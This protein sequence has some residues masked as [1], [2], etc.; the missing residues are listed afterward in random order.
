V[1]A[2]KAAT[3]TIPIAFLI[4]DDPV[5]LGLVAS[6]VDAAAR[7]MGLQI[8]VINANT[9]LAQRCCATKPCFFGFGF[10]ARA[11]NQIT[12]LKILIFNH[13]VAGS[14][15]ARLTKIIQKN[16]E[17]EESDPAPCAAIVIRLHT[18]ST[19]FAGQMTLVCPA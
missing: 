18:I 8:Q 1:L 4:G 12:N 5:K 16:Q 11:G 10:P 14:T 2:A 17:V 13:Q 9:S 19:A 6:F 7:P 15:P 3:T